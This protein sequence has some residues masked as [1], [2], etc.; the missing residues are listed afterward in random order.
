M[1]LPWSACLTAIGSFSASAVRVFVRVHLFVE[2]INSAPAI[3]L[4]MRALLHWFAIAIKQVLSVSQFVARFVV[5]QISTLAR[6][7]TR[8]VTVMGSR[9]V[10]FLVR[11]SKDFLCDAAYFSVCTKRSEVWR[12]LRT[13]RRSLSRSIFPE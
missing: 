12:A 1:L 5:L 3:V 2:S 8:I 9:S 13:S 6:T 7:T 11:F 4:V 10:R